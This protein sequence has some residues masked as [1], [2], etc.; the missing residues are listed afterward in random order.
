MESFCRYVCIPSFRVVDKAM[1]FFS[2]TEGL[3]SEINSDNSISGLFVNPRS[4]YA[5]HLN[6]V[7]ETVADD[8]DQRP[9]SAL[10]EPVYKSIQ[11]DDA[12]VMG[13]IVANVAWDRYLANLLPDTVRGFVAVLQ[14]NC[15]QA[16]TYELQGRTVRVICE[17]SIAWNS[18][19]IHFIPAGCLSWRRG[20]P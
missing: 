19:L 15:D 3:F 11:D 10:V 12:E 13:A 16:H 9:H 2:L 7:E 14:N 6:I 17:Q 5:F 4:H 20:S 18:T 8:F 1:L